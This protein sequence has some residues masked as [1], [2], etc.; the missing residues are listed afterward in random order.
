M[1]MEKASWYTINNAVEIDSPALI[2]YPDRIKSNIKLLK[3]FVSDL[4]QLRPHVKTNKCAD[5]I[6]MMLDAG[7]TKFKCAT[8]AEAELLAEQGAPDVL[9]AYQPVGPKVARFCKL[10]QQFPATAFSCLIDGGKTLVELSENAKKYNLTIRVF[11]DLNVGMNRTGISPAKAGQLY[12]QAA[13]TSGIEVLGFHAYDGHIHDADPKVRI[14][15]YEEAFA[16]VKS[17]RA[18][19]EAKLGTKPVL[20]AG[21][22]PTFPLHAKN[23]DVECSPGTFVFWDKGYQ[24]FLTDQPF[25]FAALVMARVISKPDAETVCVDL[26]HKSIASENPLGMRVYFLNAPELEPVGH[27]EEHLVLRA[28][29]ENMYQVGDILYG[30]P[31]H[32]CPTVALYDVASACSDNIVRSTWKITARKRKISI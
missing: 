15:K 16:A 20:V 9:L 10:Q 29:K 21:G 5:V 26:G 4:G 32:I 7:I 8:I 6:R 19:I 13:Q 2:V 12:E 17:L 22:T 27:S 11:I 31:H 24:Q 25:Q 30:V 14:R 18:D 28:P 3:T 1:V 23:E